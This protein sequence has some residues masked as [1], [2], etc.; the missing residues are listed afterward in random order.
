MIVDAHVHIGREDLISPGML[1][2]LKTKNLSGDGLKRLSPEGLIKEMDLVGIDRAIVFPLSF[3]HNH[4]EQQVLNDFTLNSVKAYPKRLTGLAVVA[5]QDVQ[6]SLRDLQRSVH[7]DGLRGI[8]FHPSMQQF[9]P[10]D[11]KMDAIYD[12]A[13]QADIPLLFHQGAGPAGHS[14]KFSQPLLMEDILLKFPRLKI[15]LAHCGRPF[16]DEA[17]FLLRKYTSVYADIS[18]NV[19]RKGGPALLRYCLLLLQVYAGAADRLF[20]GT[21]YPIFSPRDYLAQ[22]R[23]A[24]T[25]GDFAGEKIIFS[26]SEVEGILGRNIYNLFGLSE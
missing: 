25:G 12:F 1:A 17:A 23:Q 11:P 2:F 10:N 9:F 13:S 24:L 7:P 26:E 6:G 20:F 5:H 16:Y 3:P 15:I 21:D 19:G 14:D 4:E 18:A 8:K 22:A